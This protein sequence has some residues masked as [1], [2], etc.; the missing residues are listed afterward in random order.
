[1]AIASRTNAYE[2]ALQLLEF[3]E[4]KD[5]F[6]SIQMYSYSKV[7]HITHICK[8]FGIDNKQDVLFFDDETRNTE[9][10]DRL[11]ATAYLL[12]KRYKN[13]EFK[14]FFNLFLFNGL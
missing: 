2:D 5:Y 4:W 10:V 9:D 14:L 13:F 7:R 12:D 1:M 8:E 11:G 3:Y 6:D